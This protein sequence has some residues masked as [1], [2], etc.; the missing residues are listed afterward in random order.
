MLLYFGRLSG[1]G[2]F[3]GSFSSGLGGMIVRIFIRRVFFTILWRS[4]GSI[5]SDVL[6]NFIKNFMLRR[7]VV[8]TVPLGFVDSSSLR[9]L[10]FFTILQ[11]RV[12]FAAAPLMLLLRESCF[13]GGG[14]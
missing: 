2:D 6:T 9:S 4:V 3:R 8:C 14:F 13:P 7:L 11:Q 5:T 12:F 1:V 10:L